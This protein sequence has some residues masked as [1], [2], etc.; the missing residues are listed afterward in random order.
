MSWKM[1]KRA[2]VFVELSVHLGSGGR[3]GE[4]VEVDN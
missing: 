2:V 1:F 3:G 4:G